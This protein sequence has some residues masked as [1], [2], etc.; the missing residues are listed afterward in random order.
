MK[1]YPQTYI[2]KHFAKLC[3]NFAIIGTS[4]FSKILDNPINLSWHRCLFILKSIPSSMRI[5]LKYFVSKW[6]FWF[7]TCILKMFSPCGE[8]MHLKCTLAPEEQRNWGW[9]DRLPDLRFCYRFPAAE[10]DLCSHI[11]LR[12]VHRRHYSCPLY[13]LCIQV[14]KIAKHK[15]PNIMHLLWRFCLCFRQ[16]RVHRI[17]LHRV[18]M[19]NLLLPYFDKM[20]RF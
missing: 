4:F 8:R 10:K 12:L 14:T 16:L 13:L 19:H 6:K 5:K 7:Y 17:I 2:T 18:S 3:E 20:I 9:M 11:G 15:L 1:L